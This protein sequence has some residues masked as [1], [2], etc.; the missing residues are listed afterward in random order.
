MRTVIQ[1]EKKSG[2]HNGFNAEDALVLD[3]V[4]E[5]CTMEGA[6]LFGAVFVRC[7]F[8]EVD[9]YWGQMFRTVF[10]DCSFEGVDFRGA[11]M[12]EC[13]FVRC[14][15]GP[16]DSGARNGRVRTQ[17]TDKMDGASA[18]V[19]GAGRRRRSNAPFMR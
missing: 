11:N 8:K 10:L 5:E 4:F 17:K 18:D 16:A 6:M 7:H 1:N 12:A 14:T 19:G 9:V 3:S 2:V 13:M 15:P